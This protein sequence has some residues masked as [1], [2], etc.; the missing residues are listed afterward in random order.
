MLLV[1]V[2][3]VGR[4]FETIV[5]SEELLLSHQPREKGWRLPV[6]PSASSPLGKAPSLNWYVSRR[7]ATN[8]L[9]RAA[10][11]PKLSVKPAMKWRWPSAS[12]TCLKIM[13]Q[14][15]FSVKDILKVRLWASDSFLE[16]ICRYLPLRTGG[17]GT[18]MA[19]IPSLTCRRSSPS[20]SR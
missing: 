11:L 13:D 1:S 18:G 14:F 9:R 16:H 7:S 17:S 3:S 12:R 6:E 15:H 19:P 10:N 4:T 2:I 5:P 20:W 8:G